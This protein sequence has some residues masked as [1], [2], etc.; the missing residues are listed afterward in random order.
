MGHGIGLPKLCPRRRPAPAQKA[1]RLRLSPTTHR[2]RLEDCSMLRERLSV[3]GLR[4]TTVGYL[5][6]KQTKINILSL[7]L[8]GGVGG[9][10]LQSA[11]P[12]H[13]TLVH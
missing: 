4:S 6:L 5:T 13:P 8:G 2:R 11:Q 12:H 9:G 7:I 1:R 10:M 3:S